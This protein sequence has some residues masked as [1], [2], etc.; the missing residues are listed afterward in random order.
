MA[1]IAKTPGG[2]YALPGWKECDAA[3][4]KYTPPAELGFPCKAGDLNRLLSRYRVAKSFRGIELEDYS[5]DTLDGYSAIFGAF[6]AYSALE[7]FMDCSGLNLAGL[8][9]ALAKYEVAESNARIKAV[10]G[11]DAFLRA[12]HEHLDRATHRTHFEDF[13]AG[14][15]A[16][17]LVLAAGVRH[18]FAHGKLTPNSGAGTSTAASGVCKEL[19]ALSLRVV[20][21]EFLHRLRCSGIVA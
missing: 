21:G 1:L 3:L 10:P 15:D 2:K 7:Q 4:A 6:L 17:T 11:H 9:P 8:L 20:E 14:K 12:I 19:A 13:L 16:N 5:A 18:I